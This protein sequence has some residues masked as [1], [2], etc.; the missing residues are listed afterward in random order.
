M[1][2]K[3]EKIPY[4]GW[5]NCYRIFNDTVEVVVTSDVGPRI[6]RYGFIG[7]FNVMC[8]K[9]DQMG[10]SGGDEWMIYGGHRLWHSPEHEIRSYY[11]D[12][13]PVDVQIIENGIK[14]SQPVEKTTMIKK[15]I[16]VVLDDESSKVYLKHTL[17][18]YNLWDVELAAWAL[19]VVAP[20]GLEVVPQE[21]L[22]TLLLPNRMLSLWPYTDMSDKRVQ[23]GSRYIFLQHDSKAIKPFKFGISNTSGWAAYFNNDDMFVK[24]FSP[25]EDMVYPDYSASM[26]ETYTCDFMTEMESLSPL[27]LLGP[28]EKVEHNEQWELFSDVKPPKN[29]EEMDKIARKHI[30]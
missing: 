10:K 21:T 1:T 29:E 17:T 2:V 30:T 19:T 9:E 5:N 3:V 6:I 28:K 13:F 27:M 20:G 25:L 22:D 11:P 26:Y 14:V 4:G 18:N 8:E 7:R 12:N 15:D 23:W 24:K 16:E